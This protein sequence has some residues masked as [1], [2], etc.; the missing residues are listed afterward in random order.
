MSS[1][2]LEA[3]SSLEA[4]FEDRTFYPEAPAPRPAFVP[5]GKW[6]NKASPEWIENREFFERRMH[7]ES[8]LRLGRTLL[9]A[10]RWFECPS[11]IFVW[12]FPLEA[13]KDVPVQVACDVT[14]S[15]LY[16]A[17]GRGWWR[18]HL[19]HRIHGVTSVVR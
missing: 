14:F 1:D 13:V 10:L 12:A 8:V 16:P 18:H 9:I 4:E 15:D 3:A 11:E 6:I 17:L 2:V 19:R 7:L 5:G